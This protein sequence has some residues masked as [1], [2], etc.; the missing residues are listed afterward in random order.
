MDDLLKH[1]LARL[2]AAAGAI[3]VFLAFA[4]PRAQ[5]Q[6][7][8]PHSFTGPTTDG[9]APNA[10][11]T[12]DPSS[13][14]YY[15][16]TALGGSGS[17]TDY[18][19]VNQGCGT[20]FRMDSAGNVSILHNFVG[21]TSDGAQPQAGLALYNG[22][23][24]GTTNYGGTNDGGTAF[25][26]NTAD[27]NLQVLYNFQGYALPQPSA[28]IMD[29][30]GN[31]YGTTQNGGTCPERPGSGCG[32]VFK[33][34]PPNGQVTTWTFTGLY[35]F[36]GRIP[37]N[38]IY[39][40]ESPSGGVIMD[41]AGNLFGTTD[42]GG[43]HDDGIVFELK[44]VASTSGSCTAYDA[45]DTILHTFDASE[46]DGGVPLAGL[47]TDSA[48]NLYGTTV[49][50]G[51]SANCVATGG[52][53]PIGCGTIFKL[54]QP[55]VGETAW[56]ETVLYNFDGPP[57]DGAQPLAGLVMDSS[58][59]LYG[60]TQV[61]GSGSC[62]IPTGD[63]TADLGCGTAFKLETSGIETAYSFA[64]PTTAGSSPVGGLVMGS[65]GNLY[66]T[67]AYGGSGTCELFPGVSLGCG[68]VFVFSPTPAAAVQALIDQVEALS[69]KKGQTSALLDP[70]Q[71]ALKLLNKGKIAGAIGSLED[72]IGTVTDF[73]NA[74][75]LTQAQYT[76]L[77]NAA[78]SVI[79][80]LQAG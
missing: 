66:G 47:I 65:A 68:T 21:G 77:V 45:S 44:C 3:F 67:T 69:L 73:Y 78:N 31:L 14:L 49:R 74:G 26:M 55:A 24:Y 23:L 30:S 76:E 52:D 6:I 19:G 54:S 15:G 58:G 41:S 39:D 48:G 36:K 50:G 51:S 34:S 16:T 27:N 35:T 72:F 33:L 60:T 61:G 11:L 40:G 18:L 1:C 2:I 20:V 56:T 80:Q 5:A 59:N 53:E 32:I 37:D 75:K 25:R 7:T 43:A 64:G 12:Y 42:Y 29:S 38:D 4:A 22:Y 70:L 9:S 8:T 28:L 10:G 17:C 63:S 79:E 57:S 46:G 13:G 71:T 62:P